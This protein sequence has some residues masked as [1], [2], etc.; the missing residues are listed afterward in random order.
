MQG[1]PAGWQGQPYAP[2]SL[3]APRPQQPARPPLLAV[4]PSPPQPT[5]RLQAPEPPPPALLKL[6]SPEELGVANGPAPATPGTA[7]GSIDWNSA[8][9]RLQ[10]LGALSFRVDQVGPA[11]YRV[12]F[13]LP[14]RQPN[15]MHCIEAAAT[16]E[17]T[18]LGLAL[19]RA[20]QWAGQAE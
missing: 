10:R 18:A 5:I 8:R 9:Q 11:G 1:L 13:L 12:T 17:A 14:S 2:S 20:E 7:A 3:P 16:T 19:Q 15:S 6:P 4:N